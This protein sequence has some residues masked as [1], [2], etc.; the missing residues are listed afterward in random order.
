MRAIPCQV[1]K[2]GI[3]GFSN[4]CIAYIVYALFVYLGIHYLLA[5]VLGFAASVINAFYWNNK[6][7]FRKNVG[8]KRNPWKALVKTFL[9]YGFSELI[10]TSILLYLLID[11]FNFSEYIAQLLRLV[12]TVPFT[13]IVNKFW[14]FRVKIED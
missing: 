4:T 2:Y 13:F 3:V 1:I 8:E 7:V 10:L 6:Y 14:S 12:V 9:T 5:N 11:I